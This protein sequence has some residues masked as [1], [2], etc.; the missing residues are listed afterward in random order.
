[1]P[2]CVVW[3]LEP[4]NGIADLNLPSR[5][6]A[7]IRRIRRRSKTR[8]RK[9]SLECHCSRCMSNNGAPDGGGSGDRGERMNVR[10]W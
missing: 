6:P 5:F 1:M 3:G 2:G 7:A 8:G 9:T 10:I 4:E